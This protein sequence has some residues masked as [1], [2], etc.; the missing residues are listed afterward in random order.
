MLQ[1][2]PAVLT[3]SVEVLEE[4]IRVFEIMGKFKKLHLD[5]IDGEFLS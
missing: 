2:V 5:I 3:D 4:K 1:V